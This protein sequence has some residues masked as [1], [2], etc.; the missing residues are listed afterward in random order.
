MNVLIAEDSATAREL[1]RRT[2]A[3]L[4]HACLVAEDGEAAW[5]LFV[6]CDPEV[7]I[8]D[9][10]MP[11]ID[12]D[13]LC[14]RVRNHPRSTYTYFILLTSLEAHAHVVRGMEAGAD[15]YLKKPFDTDDLH[16]T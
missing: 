7:V 3:S 12:G 8:S 6:R 14:R 2:L 9:W 11:G 13:E 1:L 15:D 5:D 10:M 16:A 4:G